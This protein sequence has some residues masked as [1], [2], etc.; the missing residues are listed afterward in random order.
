[1]NLLR[2]ILRGRRE[3]MLLDRVRELEAQNERL[4]LHI[5]EIR[6]IARIWV[7]TGAATDDLDRIAR[8]ATRALTQEA[9][10]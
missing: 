4:I 1:M 2:R 9:Q 8:V 3:R 7:P 5:R 10:P 6:D